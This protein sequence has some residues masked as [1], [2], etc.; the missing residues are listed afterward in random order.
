MSEADS[1]TLVDQHGG[2]LPSP[3]A[4]VASTHTRP[5]ASPEDYQEEPTVKK[6]TAVATGLVAV[7]VGFLFG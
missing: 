2:A 1:T 7:L 6:S 5:A 4:N 3:Q